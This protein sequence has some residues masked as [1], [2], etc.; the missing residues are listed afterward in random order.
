[1]GTYKYSAKFRADAMA[2]A[3]S[4]G[5]ARPAYRCR[6]Q[7]EPRGFAAVDQ[8]RE[9]AER[10]EADAK[11]AKDAEIAALRKQVCEL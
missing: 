2:L 7:H 4:S 9:K 10:P 5:P 8:D 3:R 6:T 11:P 1:M